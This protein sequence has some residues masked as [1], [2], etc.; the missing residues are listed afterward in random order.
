MSRR[1]ELEP[2]QMFMVADRT[3]LVTSRESVL[4]AGSKLGTS[5]SDQIAYFF[6][7]T[8]RVNNTDDTESVTV[9]L[10][11]QDANELVGDILAGLDVLLAAQRDTRGG[12]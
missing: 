5:D 11:P 1:V 10:S 6:T 9:A 12:A 7:F 3:I 4:A 2:G 8:G